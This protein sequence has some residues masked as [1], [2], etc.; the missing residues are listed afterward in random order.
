MAGS[1]RPEEAVAGTVLLGGSDPA[2]ATII[3]PR[4]RSP[5]LLIGDHAGN[6][7]PQALGTLGLG[8]EDRIRH[9]AW[10]IGVGALGE[11]LAGRLDAV[12]VRQSYSRLVIDCNRDPASAEA[13]V[14]RS[15]GTVVPGNLGLSAEARGERVRAIHAPYHHAIAAEIE[16]RAAIGQPTWLVSLHS[17]TPA[18]TGTVRPWEIGVLHDGA[19]DGLALRL[20][21]W[22]RDQ[23]G[24]VVGDNEPYQMDA[25]DHSV[26]RHAF[27][28]HPYVE[29]ELSQRVLSTPEGIERWAVRLEAAFRAMGE[30][31]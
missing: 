17:F 22:L 12:F 6:A 13:V 1:D 28:S 4:G 3:N 21:A 24:L 25:T 11:Q 10:D 16:R 8:Q 26:P 15:D 23:P 19:N 5:F 29:I 14:E 7:I 30:E 20:L 2:S 9:I 31:T 18:M 27:P